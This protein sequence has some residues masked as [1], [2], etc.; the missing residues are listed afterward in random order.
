M[1][2]RDNFVNLVVKKVIIDRY[3]REKR[4]GESR[5]TVKFLIISLHPM[6]NPFGR[7]RFVCAC[8]RKGGSRRVTCY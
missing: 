5:Y 7:P 8:S 6:N 3:W 4:E 2:G 1:R